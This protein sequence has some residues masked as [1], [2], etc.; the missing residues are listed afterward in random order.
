MNFSPRHIALLLLV[1]SQFA[2]SAN[3]LSPKIPDPL[4]LSWCLERAA[5]A[6]PRIAMDVASLAA[7][8]ERVG[9]SGALEDPRI[10][11]EASNIPIGDFN[12]S[13]TP[14]SGNQLGLKQKVPFPGVL[15]NREAAARASAKA[16]GWQVEDRRL[17]IAATVERAWAELGFADRAL[18]ITD[19]NIDFLRQLTRIAETKYSVGTGLQQD[20][21]RA[22]VELTRLLNERLARIATIARAEATLGAL[23]DLPPD[24]ELPMT[25]ELTDQAALPKLPDLLSR[26]EAQ[27]PLLKQLEDRIDEAEHL[28]KVAKFEGY[29]DFDL[30]VGYRIR[31]NVS[32]DPVNG[33]DFFSAGVTIRLPVD[34][35]KWQARV[36]EREALTRRARAEYRSVRAELRDRLRSRFASL[37]QADSEVDLVGAGLIPQARQSLESTRSGYEV[38]KVDFLSLIDSQVSLLEAELR[39]ERAW[40]DR[41]AAFAAVEAEVGETLR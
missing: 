38:D 20:V 37:Q 11:Y 6:N 36:A 12:F 18:A 40:A 26:I 19:R 29:P 9:P 16:A 22:Q 8:S 14:L 5:Q 33:D 17:R 35:K 2:P 13:S 21:L 1:V 23:L 7:A 4:S 15:G 34:R 31:R 41:R 10:A 24:I 25:E 32:G 28:Q 30:G 3:A 27:S 39:L